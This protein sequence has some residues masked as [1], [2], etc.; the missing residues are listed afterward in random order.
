[1]LS[2]CDEARLL[3]WFQVLE[4]ENCGLRFKSRRLPSAWLEAAFRDA[5]PDHPKGW[6]ATSSRFSFAGYREEL[7]VFAV[8]LTAREPG[9]LAR[10]RRT[11]ASIIDSLIELDGQPLRAA[12][13]QAIGDGDLHA[14]EE[15]LPELERL[16]W[17]PWPYKRFSGFADKAL[18]DWCAGQIGMIRRYAEVGCPLWGFLYRQPQTGVAYVHLARP[19]P[20]YW[21]DGCR[22][23]GLHCREYLGQGTSVEARKWEEPVPE[24]D[25]LGAFQY[26][27]HVERPLDFL[28]EALARARNLL[29]VLDAGHLPTAIQH[30]TGWNLRSL[31]FAA[32]LLGARV[33]SGFVPI[34]SS[35]NE[36]F[37]M[38]RERA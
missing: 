24:F 9:A 31:R 16:A 21:G 34:L 35:G 1:M 11:L 33:A 22:R 13:L 10:S 19:E 30:H 36:A 17:E 18:W 28:R 4:C 23:T 15:A 27:D 14:L 29:L 38:V 5:V 12:M 7:A 3:D 32:H 25:L 8:A 26:L 37:L 20:N 6:D 2:G